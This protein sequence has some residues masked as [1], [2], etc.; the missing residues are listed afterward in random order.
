MSN[1]YEKLRSIASE[2]REQFAH[3][4]AG[5]PY[6]KKGILYSEMFFLWTCVE[7]FGVR[8]R[9]ILES[10]RARG[11]STLIL[12]KIF[13][14]CDIVSVEYD[15]ESPDVSIAAERLRS[16]SNVR[17]LFGDATRLLPEIIKPGDVVLID[18]PKGFRG[19][20]L[21]IR[22]LGSGTPSLVF[23]HD[24]IA[25]SA[26]RA[27]LDRHLPDTLFSD[28]PAIASET[29]A[30]DAAATED[31]PQRLRFSS[32]Q[33]HY[34]YSLACLRGNPGLSTSKLLLAAGWAGMRERWGR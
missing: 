27:F 10:G 9:R 17:L 3:L 7:A 19:L 6:E 1:D 34:G 11:Q 14:D 16:F 21:A 26:D 15:P 5:V 33:P 8:P 4:L 29:H 30:L 2:K 25:G 13:P 22:L 24:T 23:V 12:A 32:S 28:M 20:R 31:M 18:G